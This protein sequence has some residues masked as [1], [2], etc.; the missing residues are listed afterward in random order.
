MA[1]ESPVYTPPQLTTYGSVEALTARGCLF[2][3]TVGSP[4]DF[5]FSIGGHEFSFPTTDCS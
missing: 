4:S 2:N 5:S 3:K 1:S